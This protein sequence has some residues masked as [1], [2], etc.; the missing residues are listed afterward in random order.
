MWRLLLFSTG[1]SARGGCCL[2]RSDRT[3]PRHFNLVESLLGPKVLSEPV[4]HGT[5][6][7][8][9]LTA[10]RWGRAFVPLLTST[11]TVRNINLTLLMATR[12]IVWTV[13]V[14]RQ[15]GSM[16]LHF[17]TNQ[18]WHASPPHGGHDRCLPASRLG[19]VIGSRPRMSWGRACSGPKPDGLR[20]RHRC[21]TLYHHHYDDLYHSYRHDR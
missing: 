2:R 11:R 4:G 14:D 7:N 8:I 16:D 15:D 17:P 13:L 21:L 10:L 5:A 12:R 19:K 6:F 18:K 1:A 3:E 20:P 9:C